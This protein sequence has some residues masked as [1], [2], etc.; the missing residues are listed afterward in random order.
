MKFTFA[1]L[2]PGRATPPA[3]SPAPATLPA[4]PAATVPDGTP[5]PGATAEQSTAP[6]PAMDPVVQARQDE[7]ARCAAI[8]AAPE[9]EGRVALAAQLA[10]TTDLSAEQ[11]VG[12][13]SVTPATTTASPANPFA[14]AMAAIPN[15]QVG[16][17]PGGGDADDPQALVAQILKAGV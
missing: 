6:T 10:F 15:P 13:M 11:A 16:T 8:F 1:H 14:V 9:A 17:E 3:Q 4:T 5:G 7:R 12:V 2:M